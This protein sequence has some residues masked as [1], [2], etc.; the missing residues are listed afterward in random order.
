MRIL[1]LGSGT[2]SLAQSARRAGYDFF[3]LDFYGDRDQKAICEN[4]SLHHDLGGEDR[5]ETLCDHASRMAYTHLVYGSGLENHPELVEGLAR[6]RT[7]LGNGPGVLRRVR[8]WR[9]FS[10][11]LRRLGLS[12]PESE[13]VGLEEGLEVLAQEPGRWL[14]KPLKGGGGR[15][16]YDGAQQLELEDWEVLLQERLNGTP[17]SA[18]VVATGGEAW[19]VGTTEQLVGDGKRPYIYRGNIAP[20]KADG[21]VLEAMEET[22]IAITRGFGL[23]GYNGLDFMIVGATPYVLEVNPRPTGA[24][25]VLE[26]AYGVNLFDL[27][28]KACLHHLEEVRIKP[29]GR[30][31]G[32]E[33]AFADGPA[34]FPGEVP[35]FL[36]DVPHPGEVVPR[37]APICTV[38]AS[39]RTRQE[40][41]R[42]L[43][44]RGKR[45][46]GLLERDRA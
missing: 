3:T 36:R 42:L 41:L 8:G 31:Y 34:P 13:V 43:G 4:Y 1:V 27:H 46:K 33:I 20:L 28:V 5:M 29:G 25:E 14:I 7:L 10:G 26:S 16:I 44:E 45:L 38:L 32:R 35:R 24:M 21:E 30:F 22:S 40:C 9:T 6:G 12:F 19:L 39:G 18:S 23:V 2:R 37:G 15:T 11:G 17:A